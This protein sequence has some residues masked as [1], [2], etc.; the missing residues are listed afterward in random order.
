MLRLSNGVHIMTNWLRY[1][2]AGL[3]DAVGD[4]QVDHITTFEQL[5]FATGEVDVAIRNGDQQDVGMFSDTICEKWRAP[6]ASP[7]IAAKIQGPSDLLAMPPIEARHPR[8]PKSRPS[9][10]DWLEAN[11]EEGTTRNV[12]FAP[13]C[14]HSTLLTFG[15]RTEHVHALWL[16]LRIE[17]RSTAFERRVPCIC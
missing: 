4:V 1:R 3:Q 6:M 7:K 17:P 2:L 16:S 8:E 12:Q 15:S 9:F 14:S 11:G 13:R 10:V 5:D